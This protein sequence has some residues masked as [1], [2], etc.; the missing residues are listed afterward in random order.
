[1]EHAPFM[2]RLRGSR[3]LKD[4]QSKQ[5]IKP[6]EAETTVKVE[7]DTLEEKVHVGSEGLTSRNVNE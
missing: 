1:M 4:E 6:D 2:L 7:P 5:R 3:E